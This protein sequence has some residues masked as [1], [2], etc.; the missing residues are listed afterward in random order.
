[1]NNVPLHSAL[2]FALLFDRMPMATGRVGLLRV[3]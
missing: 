3:K 1:M 2:L